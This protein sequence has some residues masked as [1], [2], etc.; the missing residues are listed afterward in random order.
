MIVQLI[1]RVSS[2]PK[3]SETTVAAS[4]LTVRGSAAVSACLRAGNARIA[5]RERAK[6]GETVE[7]PTSA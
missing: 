7:T 4:L 1:A 3:M 6:R 2:V 5:T